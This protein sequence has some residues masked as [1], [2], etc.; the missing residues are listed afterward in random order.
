MI[1]S[2][3]F[4]KVELLIELWKMGLVRQIALS[5]AP[6]SAENQAYLEPSL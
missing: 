4:A 2:K 5:S 6:F 3:N 1:A